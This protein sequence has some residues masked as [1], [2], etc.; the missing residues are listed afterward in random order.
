M[1]IIVILIIVW[2]ILQILQHVIK[3]LAKGIFKFLIGVIVVLFPY[4]VVIWMFYSSLYPFGL[5]SITLYIASG[6]LTFL[7]HMSKNG[8]LYTISAAIIYSSGIVLYD[9]VQDIPSWACFI[10]ALVGMIILVPIMHKR[11]EHAENKS[12]GAGRIYYFFK[13]LM[14][15]DIFSYIVSTWV[16]LMWC[17]VVTD[18]FHPIPLIL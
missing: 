15:V 2:I 12:F 9:L 14:V 13:K 7:S 1:Y 3:S 16:L 17:L 6:I 10:I 18:V 8:S 4:V 5:E 11:N